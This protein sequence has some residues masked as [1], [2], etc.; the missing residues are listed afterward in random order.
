MNIKKIFSTIHQISKK[1]KVDVHAVGGYV[2]DLLLGTKNKADIDFV[3]VGSGLEF[4]K[5][6]AENWDEEGTLIEFPDFDTARF[7][8][9][10][11]MDLKVE[12]PEKNFDENQIKKE[13]LF[14]IEFAGARTEKYESNSRKPQVVSTDLQTDLSRRDFTVNAMARKVG[15][16][17]LSKKIEDYFDGQKDLEKKIIRNPLNPDITFSEDPL[18]MLRAARFA[19]QLNFEIDKKTYQAIK[20]NKERLKII[21]A[22]RIQEEFFKLLSTPKPSIGLWILYETG[23]LQEFLPEVCDLWG[24]DEV[25]GHTHKNNLEHTFKV[26]D[27]LAERSDKKLLRYAALMHDIGKPGTKQFVPKRGWAFDM[28]E[29]LGRKIVRDISK[30]LRMSKQDTEYVAKLVR[31]HQQPIALMDEGI[32]DS[33]VRRLVVNLQDDLVDLLTLC[34]SDITT[35]NPKKLEKRLKNYDILESRIAE[36]LEKDKLRAF[37][38]PVRGEEIMELCNLKPGPTVGRIKKALE[39]AILDGEVQ[40]DYEKVKEYFFTIKDEYMQSVQEWEKN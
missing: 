33:P 22:E 5:K 9:T 3:V 17:G 1:E 14:E 25:Y 6:F 21:S 39:D 15:A 35:G 40:N 26:V 32:T 2:R 37:N 12:E 29:H 10:R 23:L 20:T 28:H 19:S 30:R 38:S 31:W 36:V 8:F 11:T 27:N 24:V 18:R 7:V 16:T 4:A 34:R 13:K